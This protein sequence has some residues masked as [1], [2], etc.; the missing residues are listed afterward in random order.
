MEGSIDTENLDKVW[1]EKYKEYLGVSAKDA[2]H[3]ILQDV[4]WGH[5]SIGYFPTYSL[6]SFYAAQ[7][8]AQAE[9]D[10]KKL[11]KKLSKG[12]TSQ[13]LTWLREN[14]HLHGRRYEADELCNRIT[15]ESLN[16]D[17]FLKYA[18]DKFLSVYNG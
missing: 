14:I 16:F 1:N 2:N 8:F 7:F 5:G 3:G 15:G 13:L 9:K 12:D 6:G 11:N 4:H 10:I 17:H 18:S